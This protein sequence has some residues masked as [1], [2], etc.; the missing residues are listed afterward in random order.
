VK[1]RL[2]KTALPAPRIPLV[3]QQAISENAPLGTKWP[4]F[5]E[6]AASRD[7]HLFDQR[8]FIQEKS[9]PAAKSQRCY[10]PMIS[11]N[12]GKKIERR[13][14]KIAQVPR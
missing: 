10:R 5:D 14:C 12:A 2:R 9:A 1:G 13:R 3:G 6:A 11:R 8:R 4:R 7:H